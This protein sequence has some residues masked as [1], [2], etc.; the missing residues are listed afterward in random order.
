MHPKIWRDWNKDCERKIV[1]KDCERKIVRERLWKKI[2]KERLWK[3]ECERMIVKE[4][5]WNKD[6]EGKIV[7]W[8]VWTKDRLWKKDSEREIERQIESERLKEKACRDVESHFWLFPF[9]WVSKKR[10]TDRQT[11]GPMDRWTNRQVDG[12]TE[13]SSYRGAWTDLKMTGNIRWMTGKYNRKDTG[14]SC[15]VAFVYNDINGGP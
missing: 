8:R 2:V 6:C 11:N 9:I 15:T 10:I 4:R 13:I 12:W 3:N 5:L 1:K 7:K 14:I